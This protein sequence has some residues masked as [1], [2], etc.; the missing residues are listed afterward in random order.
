MFPWHAE[1]LGQCNQNVMGGGD[2]KKKQCLPTTPN[3]IDFGIAL[4]RNG[5][6]LSIVKLSN[7]VSDLLLRYSRGR[8]YC[9]N[10]SPQKINNSIIAN[11]TS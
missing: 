5:V 2:L 11:R 8:Y 3:M 4:V 10:K 6:T 9:K 1:C 7:F